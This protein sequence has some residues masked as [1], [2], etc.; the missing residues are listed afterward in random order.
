VS[1]HEILESELQKF[2]VELSQERKIALAIYCDEIARWNKKINLTGLSGTALVRRLVAEPAWIAGRLRLCGNLLDIGSGNGS[3]ALPFSIVS[4]EVTAVHL[5]EARTKRA[6]FLRHVAQLLELK[7]TVHRARL[8]D[9]AAA[10]IQPDW[11]SLQGVAIDPLLASIRRFVQPTTQIVW[12]TSTDANTELRPVRTLTV[13]LT[14]T[15]AFLFQL[16]LS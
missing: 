4:G 5:V 3:P 12:I 16:D 8:E 10:L 1:H 14:G 7:A 6:A 11:I 9:L 2:E 15:R 13:P